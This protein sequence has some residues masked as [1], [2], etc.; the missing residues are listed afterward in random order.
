[1]SIPGTGK[2][3]RSPSVP[4]FAKEQSTDK[5]EV[6]MPVSIVALFSKA[7]SRNFR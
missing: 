2:V 3:S 4:L 1:M 7:D 6:R 5:K